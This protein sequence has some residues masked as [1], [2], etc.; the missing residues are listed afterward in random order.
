MATPGVPL[1]VR[2]HRGFCSSP[3]LSTRRRRP[4]LSS[5]LESTGYG[6]G[7]CFSS[8]SSPLYVGR[9]DGAYLAY[10]EQQSNFNPT[11]IRHRNRKTL[12][13]RRNWAGL[14]RRGCRKLAGTG[15][16]RPLL[17]EIRE[18]AT[19]KVLSMVTLEMALT[20]GSSRPPLCTW[21]CPARTLCVIQQRRQAGSV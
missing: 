17:A 10:E 8:L 6:S 4:L 11:R 7:W 14:G 20:A 12:L 18:C 9:G 16:G 1:S 2:A 15:G 13:G 3:S 19:A 5:P 21:R